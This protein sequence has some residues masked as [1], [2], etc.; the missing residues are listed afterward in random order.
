MKEMFQAGTYHV[1]AKGHNGSLPMSVTLS[2][3]RIEK[4]D[5]ASSKESKG[6][7]YPVFTTVPSSIIE[8]Q[9]LNVDTVSGATISSLGII[10]GVADAIREAGGDPEIFKKRPKP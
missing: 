8:G 6:I 3:D 4:I 7:S 1:R 5:V 9:A 10:E 2:S